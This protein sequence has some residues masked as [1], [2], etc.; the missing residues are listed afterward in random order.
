MVPSGGK[1]TSIL[2][3]VVYETVTG[4]MLQVLYTSTRT[5][6]PHASYLNR[7]HNG[8]ASQRCWQSCD[9]RCR[10][11]RYFQVYQTSSASTRLHPTPPPT[12]SW[13]HPRKAT[14]ALISSDLYTLAKTQISDLHAWANLATTPRKRIIVPNLTIMKCLEPSLTISIINHTI[15][16]HSIARERRRETS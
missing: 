5:L 3:Y 12:S 9:S 16:S 7:F 1:H 11:Y 14:L 4:Y 6:V 15:T 2:A 13:F 8:G 10:Q